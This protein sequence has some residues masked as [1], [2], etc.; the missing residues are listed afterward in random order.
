MLPNHIKIISDDNE[1]KF[2]S[3]TKTHN[4]YEYIKSETK[5]IKSNRMD[6]R[7]N[8]EVTNQQDNSGDMTHPLEK[9][10]FGVIPITAY[11]GVLITKIIGG[12]SCLNQTCIKP[13]EVDA[14]IDASLQNLKQT[15]NEKA[16]N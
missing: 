15:L 2:H 11:R 4:I 3:K 16:N 14:I 9:V 13:Q 7:R 10:H 12:Y 1:L 8:K 5:K 6:G